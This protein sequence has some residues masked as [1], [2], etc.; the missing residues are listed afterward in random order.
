MKKLYYL[1]IILFI[2][3]TYIDVKAQSETMIISSEDS[4]ECGVVPGIDDFTPVDKEPRADIALL[5]KSIV[6]PLEA[7]RLGIQ[8][9]VIIRILISKTGKLLNSVIQTSDSELLNQG[10]L[11]ALKS[12]K[13]L[14]ATQ[15]GQKICCWVSIPISF[16]LK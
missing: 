4:L 12:T 8:G 5:Q 6:Y 2:I 16:K 1:F 10:A 14:P 3:F 13:F 9:N 11:D 15:H 7:R